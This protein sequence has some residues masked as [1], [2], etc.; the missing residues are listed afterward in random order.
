M[1]Y[2]T[3]LVYLL[4]I[5]LLLPDA[6]WEKVVNQL[7]LL[8]KREIVQSES[9]IISRDS[10]NSEIAEGPAAKNV[11][12]LIDDNGILF[13]KVVYSQAVHETANFTST[14]FKENNNCFG[15]KR[16]Q[17]GW[18]TEE[19]RGHASY[20]SIEESVRDY[21]A[22]QRMILYMAKQHG[23]IINSDEQY[24]WLL[25]NLPF[26]KGSRYAEDPNYTK[27]LRSHMKKLK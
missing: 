24:L 14:I 11:K 26:D 6:V 12:A 3:G 5:V 22:Y 10:L 13:P 9:S 18:A 2:V 8:R 27:S 21:A 20:A 7:H 1:K 23:Y 19:N 4:L 25:D 15:M 16:S 17:R